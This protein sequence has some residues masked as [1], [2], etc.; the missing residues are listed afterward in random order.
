MAQEPISTAY[1]V[2]QQGPHPGKRIEICKDSTTIGRSRN[3]DIFLEDVAVHRKQATIIYSNVGYLL[4]DDHGGND[5]LV[6]GRPVKEQ[7]L[8]D[9]DQLVFGN[10]QLIFFSHE[11]TRTFQQFSSRGR[12]LHIEKKPESHTSPIAK[13]N[14]T[15]MRGTIQSFDLSPHMTIGRS[16]DCSIFLEDLAVSRLHATIRQLSDGV[17]ELEDQHSATGTFVN[18]QAIIRCRLNEGDIV[19]IGSSRFTFR[20]APV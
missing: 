8:K 15:S 18:G 5:S 19:Q 14:L 6:N 7:L 1:L 3:C 17:Y 2:I 13:L 4:R 12:E 10:T 11:T 9:G 20:L 16:R